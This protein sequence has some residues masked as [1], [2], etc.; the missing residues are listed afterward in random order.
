MK[1][2][3]TTKARPFQSEMFLNVHKSRKDAEK[4]LRSEFPHMRKTGDSDMFSSDKDTNWL[5]FIHERE[6]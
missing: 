6:I 1:V 5:L 3:V 4:Y 2:Y